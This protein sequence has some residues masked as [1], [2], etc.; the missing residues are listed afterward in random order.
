LPVSGT[1]GAAISRKLDL[2]HAALQRFDDTRPCIGNAGY[3]EGREGDVCD[4]H[5]YWGWYYNS[6]LTFLNLRDR[7]APKPLFGDPAKRQPLTFTECVGAFTGP[8]GEFNVVRSKQLAPRLGWIGHTQTPRED[9]LRYQAFLVR[10]TTE[11]F[12]RMRPLNPRLAGVMPFTILFYN[13][14]GITAFEQMQPKPAL[15]QLRLS[16]QPVLLSWELWTPHAHAGTQLRP[17]AHVVNDDDAGRP[18][19]GAR[20]VWQLRTSDGRTVGQGQVALPE[21]P[22]FETCRKPLLIELPTNSPTGDYILSGR[23]VSGGDT[24]STNWCELF[25]AGP[26]WRRAMPKPSRPVWL[27]DPSGQTA[28]SLNQLGIPFRR[29]SHPAPPWPSEMK[30]L[31]LG[32]RAWDAVLGAKRAALKRFVREGGR[33]LCLQP[34]PQNF[35]RDWLPAEIEF[36]TASANDPDYPPRSRPFREQSHVNPERPD[37]P[38]F[39]GLSRERLRLWS[40]YTG[41]DETQPGFPKLHPV[42]GGFKLVQPDALARAAVLADYDRGLEGIALCELFDG[43]GSVILSGFDLV[44]RVG[45]DPVAE[46]LLANLIAYAAAPDGHEP[47]PLIEQPIRWGDFPTEHG[48]V[49]GPLNGLLVHCE[50]Q[51]PATH[52]NAEPLPPNTGS[53]NMRPG[54]Q[55]VPR[56]RNPFGPFGYSTGST[57]RDLHPTETTGSGFFWARIPSGKRFVVTLAH[58]P[59]ASPATLTVELNGRK[60]APDTTVAPGATVE[61]RTPLPPE[62]T[63]VC[64]RYTSAKTL[65]LRE[66]RFE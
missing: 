65:V 6:F 61:A 57:L 39:A 22:Y 1:R 45:T 34:D 49:C 7:L 60:T 53:W 31:V 3:G 42:T 56:G 27:Y 26:D 9:A 24:R 50:W 52:P 11:L 2:L 5:R 37:H 63:R 14:S 13:W 44:N 20:L 30:V 23:I 41:W 35:E 16:Y 55:F 17:I 21:I 25:V 10:Q 29:L 38:V 48:V 4:V 66:T 47:H 46:R 40:D 18:L 59:D 58:N 36:L 54:E 51:P 33:V 15:D 8:T 62:T 28:A 43:A 19:T 12:R 32:E 64:V